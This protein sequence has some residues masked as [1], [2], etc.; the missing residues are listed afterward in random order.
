MDSIDKGGPMKVLVIDEQANAAAAGAAVWAAT[1][2]SRTTPAVGALTAAGHEIVRCFDDGSPAHACKGLPG[3]TGCPVAS[4]GVDVV[5]AVSVLERS[6]LAVDGAR[7]AARQFLPF[8]TMDSGHP[9]R[10]WEAGFAEALRDSVPVVH[11]AGP[12]DLGAAVSEAATSPLIGHGV[13]ATQALRE[14]LECHGVPSGEA[15]ASARRNGRGVRVAMEPGVVL[16]DR[17]ARTAAVRVAAAVRAWDPA[18]A[19]VDVTLG[20]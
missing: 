20:A 5:V 14:V 8:V 11:A 7:C 1:A 16:D 19:G 10:P 4:G 15:V 17:V 2:A 13:A 9:G 12:E 3:G 18:A 6:P